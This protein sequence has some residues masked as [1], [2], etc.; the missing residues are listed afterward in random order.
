[1]YAV[2]VLSRLGHA[3][4]GAGRGDARFYVWCL[5]WWPHALGAGLNPFTPHVIW[6]PRGLDMAWATGLPGPA[7]ALAPVTLAFGPVVASNVAAVIGPPLAG[8]AGYLLC[9]RAADRFWP[10]FAGGWLIGFSTYMVSQMRGHLNLSLV[11]P[12][13][14]AA[15]LVVR[16]VQGELTDRRF[17]LLFAFVLIAEFSISTEVFATMTVFGAGAIAGL[18]W[19]VPALREQ[20][21]RTAIRIGLGYASAGAVLAPYLWYVLVGVPRGPIRP[22]MSGRVGEDLLTLVVPRETTL[23]GGSTFHA[24]TRHLEPNLSEDGGYMG[25]AL[26]AVLG[27]AW[28]RARRSRDEVTRLVLI[29]GAG[30][31]VLALGPWLRVGGIDTHVPLPDIVLA[32]VPILQDALPQRFTLYLWIATGVVVARWFA[33]N[34]RT[35]VRP[36]SMDV[37]PFLAFIVTAAALLP[38]VFAPGLH[39]IATVPAYFADGLWRGTVAS[40]ETVLILHG[41]KGQ[42]MLWQAATWMGFSMAQGHSGPE[43][44]SF[45]GD[46]IWGAIRDDLPGELDPDAFLAW[47]HEHDVLT[48]IAD[49]GSA[50]RWSTELSLTLGDTPVR[51][52]GVDVYRVPPFRA[53]R[54]SCRPR[55]HEYTPGRSSSR[56]GRLTLRGGGPPEIPC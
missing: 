5:V 56:S 10:A 16:H 30:A 17:T 15:Y 11:F 26:L 53:R 36:F 52:G 50:A 2:P 20:L 55:S 46:P 19:R 54:G 32:H 21:R 44:A 51:V 34:T 8:W 13:P 42:E 1:L 22:T 24:P 28:R 23:V 9:R 29:F 31:A 40:G 35:D 12:V 48:V 38:N 37:R 14:L 43:P 25:L 3:F 18:W 49:P 33:G 4:V 39:G 41:E 27:L 7:L 45:R 47:L 6:A